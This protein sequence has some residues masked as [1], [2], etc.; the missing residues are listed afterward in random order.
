MDTSHEERSHRASIRQRMTQIRSPSYNIDS[1]N[2]RKLRYHENRI[3]SLCPLSTSDIVSMF[4]NLQGVYTHSYRFSRCEGSVV[5]S[6]GCSGYSGPN[7]ELR[8]SENDELPTLKRWPWNGFPYPSH[9]FR[10][11]SVLVMSTYSLFVSYLTLLEKV[12][13][14]GAFLI[15]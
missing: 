4:W 7:N 14:N 9:F 5:S 11:L 6:Q 10:F 13:L 1:Q 12:R 15:S 2:A 3:L 8:T